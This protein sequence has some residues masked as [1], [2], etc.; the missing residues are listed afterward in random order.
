MP[1][2][3]RQKSSSG[4]YHV[5][6]RGINRQ[7]IFEDEEDYGKFLQTILKCKAKCGY[8]IHA[9]CLMSNHVHLLIKVGKES[10]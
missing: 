7:T 5:M 4:I 10:F 3:A 8:T 9:Y 6:M 2:K 1:R